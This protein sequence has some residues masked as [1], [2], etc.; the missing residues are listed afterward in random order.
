VFKFREDGTGYID[1]MASMV[2]HIGAAKL[3]AL[4]VQQGAWF[5]WGGKRIQGKDN[6]LAHLN[7]DPA[8]L[9]KL[10]DIAEQP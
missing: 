9:D 4:G 1:V 3:A 2:A 8:N 5:T 6:F 7:E 10:I